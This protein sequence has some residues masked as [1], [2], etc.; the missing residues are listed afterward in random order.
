M[1]LNSIT[2][3]C[4]DASLSDSGKKEQYDRVLLDA[5]A[6]VWASSDASLR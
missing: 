4:R 6:R 3:E 2:A 5:P 1:G